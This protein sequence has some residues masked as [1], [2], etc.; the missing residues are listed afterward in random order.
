[1][2]FLVSISLILSSLNG[3]AQIVLDRQLIGSGYSEYSNGSTFTLSASVGE[4]VVKTVETTNLIISQGFQQSNFVLLEPFVLTFEV[5]SVAC[6][7][8]NNGRV[9]V[10]FVSPNVPTPH[11]YQWSTGSS[12]TVITQLEHGMYS[13]TITGSNGNMVTN[14]VNLRVIDSTNCA[15]R[16]YT[17]ITPNG[18]NLND[19]WTIENAEFFTV[20]EVEIFNRYGALVWKSDDYNNEENA[21]SGEHR[22]GQPLVDGTYF[23][24][25]KFDDSVYKGWI[26]ISR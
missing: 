24:I 6:L 21:F 13:L 19:F 10:S 4:P 20:R 22:G 18:D 26:E 7:G 8:A 14:S 12:D 17:G 2:K 15:P 16:F 25:A 1:M 9:A 23:F 3:F 11:V 5:D